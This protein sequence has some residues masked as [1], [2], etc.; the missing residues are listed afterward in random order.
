[1]SAFYFVEFYSQ[2]LTSTARSGLAKGLSISEQVKKL[3]EGIEILTKEL[4]KCVLEK[5]EDLLLQASHATKLE[6]VLGAM[7]THVQNLFANAERLKLQV[8]YF[9]VIILLNMQINRVFV[10][11]IIYRIILFWFHSYVFFDE[12]LFY[13]YVDIGS[14]SSLGKS[15]ESFGAVA[16]S[17][18]YFK[19]SK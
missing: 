6:D 4:Q 8:I 11:C 15:Y 17:E 18:S 19:T 14:L 12:E 7:N 10:R 5:H 16:S 2:F 13:V 1:M 9:S 3:G